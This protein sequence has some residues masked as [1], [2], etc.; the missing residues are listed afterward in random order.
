MQFADALTGGAI[1]G[2]IG[3]VVVLLIGVGILWFG[4]WDAY[5]AGPLIV[6]G[7]VVIVVAIG[8]YV[9]A[10]WPFAYDYHHWVDKKVR[11][12]QVSS[13]LLSDGDNG[14]SQKFVVRDVEGGLYGIQDTR[15]AL[16]KPGD[17]LKLRCK[18]AYQFGIPRAADGWDCRWS[19]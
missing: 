17:V 16:V 3:A 9:W 6:V 18:R 10:M 14:I 8:G 7:V 13:R 2:T 11:V 19:A 4:I 15:G 1:G 5:D 12:A